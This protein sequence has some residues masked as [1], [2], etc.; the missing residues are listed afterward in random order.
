MPF[1]GFILNNYEKKKR[2]DNEIQVKTQWIWAGMCMVWKLHCNWYSP[3]DN[4]SLSLQIVTVFCVCHWKQ[5]SSPEAFYFIMFISELISSWWEAFVIQSSMVFH[6]VE[7]I[8]DPT[9]IVRNEN[10]YFFLYCD[11]HNGQSSRQVMSQC[12]SVT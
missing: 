8:S 6:F 9:H 4:S 7:N 1:W 2:Q 10:T 12:S 3:L 11:Q 5:C